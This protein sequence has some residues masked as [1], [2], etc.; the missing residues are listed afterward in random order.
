MVVTSLR[1]GFPRRLVG[2]LTC[3]QFAPF[4]FWDVGGMHTFIHIYL[5]VCL[6]IYLL[7]L[8][9]DDDNNKVSSELSL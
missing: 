9:N 8:A 1:D 7:T 3:G 4:S 6:F 5:F 2:T